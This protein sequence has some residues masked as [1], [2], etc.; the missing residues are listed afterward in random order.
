MGGKVLGSRY[1]LL[2][3]ALCRTWGTDKV[4]KCFCS[5]N[6]VI[7]IRK[8]IIYHCHIAKDVNH[9]ESNKRD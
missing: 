6:K 8:A 7:K 1:W 9:T 2:L 3:F 5:N 4:L